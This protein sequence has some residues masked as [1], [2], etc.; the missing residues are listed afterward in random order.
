MINF[1]VHVCVCV[2]NIWN[3]CGQFDHFL[4]GNVQDIVIVPKSR[5]CFNIFNM[6]RTH[7][8]F[9]SLDFCL[10]DEPIQDFVSNK[11]HVTSPSCSQKFGTHRS[12]KG[13]KPNPNLNPT[14]SVQ[15]SKS[16]QIH[17][18]VKQNLICSNM[19]S[20]LAMLLCLSPSTIHPPKSQSP[21]NKYTHVSMQNTKATKTKLKIKQDQGQ[22]PP[23]P[24]QNR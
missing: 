12:N 22:Q 2:S 3:P 21:Y 8:R 18:K 14:Q 19:W 7:E 5:Q 11:V 10:T 23:Q 16:M 13:R 17:C 9:T 4:F 6:W 24:K 20:L 15:S 1:T